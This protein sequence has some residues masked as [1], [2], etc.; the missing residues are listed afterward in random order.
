MSEQA[1]ASF[2][3][4]PV[5]IDKIGSFAGILRKRNEDVLSYRERVIKAYRELYELDNE[6]FWRSLSYITTEKEIN[7]GFLTVEKELI[8][9]CVIKITNEKIEIFI[10]DQNHVIDFKENKFL[11][12]VIEKIQSI[13]GLIFETIEE[14]KEWMFRYSRNL[15]PKSSERVY[16]RKS[17]SSLIEESPVD[18]PIEFYDWLDRN[19]ENVVTD[20]V[21]YP[22]TSV[23][24]E[25]FIQYKGFPLLLTWN[26]F[27]ALSCNKQ[28]FKNILKDENGLITQ[29]GA[30]MINK[31]LEKQNTYWGE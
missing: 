31:I 22:S 4:N 3:K 5:L 23:S 15:I 20:G 26:P 21:L 9:N 30:K 13:P 18:Y 16:L 27:L 8:E 7:V 29:K 24:S 14:E 10:E 6:S 28:E 11:I 12:D 17:T 1:V 2:Q 25:G 19:A